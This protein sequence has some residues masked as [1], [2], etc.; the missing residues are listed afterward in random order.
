MDNGLFESGNNKT[1]YY[2]LYTK[3][4][5]YYGRASQHMQWNVSVAL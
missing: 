1:E 4:K 5:V 3:L 2:I